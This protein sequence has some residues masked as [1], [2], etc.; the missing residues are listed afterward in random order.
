MPRNLN[1][2]FMNSASGTNPLQ[3]HKLFTTVYQTELNHAASFM[4]EYDECHSPDHGCEHECIN[5]LGKCTPQ[6]GSRCEHECINTLS[7]CTPQSVSRK[8]AVT[9]CSY[10]YGSP[11]CSGGYK[12]SCRLGYELHSDDKRCENACGGLIGT[13]PVLT[14]LHCKKGKKNR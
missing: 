4:K 1:C 10:L 2:T 13:L 11:S 12:C 8:Y 7:K 3:V 9:L 6:S 5:T 14:T